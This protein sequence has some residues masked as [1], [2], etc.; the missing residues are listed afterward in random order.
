MA[1]TNWR[2]HTPQGGGFAGFGPSQNDMPKKFSKRVQKVINKGSPQNV[3]NP[4][5]AW[6]FS[7][8]TNR[9]GGLRSPTFWFSICQKPKQNWSFYGPRFC[10]DPF[11]TTFWALFDH[12][13]GMSFGKAQNHSRTT[14]WPFPFL[15]P[16]RG[17]PTYKLSRIVD[18]CYK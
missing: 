13:L 9:G 12:F 11:L 1:E 4:K 2:A 10:G 14:F 18:E 15:G 17:H 6:A 3:E 7:V 16:L 8:L 5:L